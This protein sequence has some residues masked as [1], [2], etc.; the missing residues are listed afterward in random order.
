MKTD[1]LEATVLPRL[2]GKIASLRRK[3]VELLQTPLRPYAPGTATMRFEESD[4]SGF[5]DCLPSVAE[6]RLEDGAWIPDHGEFWRLPYEVEQSSDDEIRLTATGSALPLRFH[7]RLTLLGDMLRVD[8][9]LE[10]A[11]ETEVPY[12]WSAHP[13]FAID[14]GD[15]LSVPESVRKVRVESSA[16]G[17]LGEKGSVLRWPVATVENGVKVDLSRSESTDSG[18]ADKLYAESPMEGWAAIERRRHRLRVG[19]GF[20]PAATP[21][22]GLWLCYG[23]WPEGHAA[24]QHCVALEPCTAPCDSLAE[25]LDK[26]L[27]RHLAPGQAA[28]WWMTITVSEARS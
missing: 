15:L 1:T 14:E 25:A 13:L 5:D 9:R 17:R 7:R 28:S 8:Y 10:N 12:L 2:G 6:C 11:G 26:G 18:A 22:L 23:G 21:H 4:A 24:R 16:R 19:V 3:G 20:D 27:A